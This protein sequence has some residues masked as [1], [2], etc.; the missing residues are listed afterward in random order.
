VKESNAAEIMSVPN[1]GGV[2]V[3][4]ASLKPGDFVPIIKSI[5]NRA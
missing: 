4:G 5:D 1:V 3:G 2:L